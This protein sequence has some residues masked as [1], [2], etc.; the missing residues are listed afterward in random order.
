MESLL[1]LLVATFLVQ[2]F[3][4]FAFGT[5]IGRPDLGKKFIKWELKWLSIGGRWALKRSLHLIAQFCTWAES[6]I[7]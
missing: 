4:V 2:A 6:K 1:L 3:I 7:P 5:L